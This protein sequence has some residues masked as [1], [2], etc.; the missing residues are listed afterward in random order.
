MKLKYITKKQTDFAKKLSKSIVEESKIFQ[1]NFDIIRRIDEQMLKNRNAR[2]TAK[3][4]FPQ[5]MNQI[6]RS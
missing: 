3:V 1:H 5:L 2:T 6:N 4:T